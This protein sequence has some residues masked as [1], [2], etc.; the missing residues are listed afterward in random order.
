MR[1]FDFPEFEQQA[2]LAGK[3][4]LQFAFGFN[5]AFNGVLCGSDKENAFVFCKGFV[6]RG[7][8]FLQFGNARADFLD[9]VLEVN[10]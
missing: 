8:N 9:L 4:F 2:I 3:T 1:V 10:G 6:E 7:K 5:Q